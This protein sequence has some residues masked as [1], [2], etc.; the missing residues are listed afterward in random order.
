MGIK[1]LDPDEIQKK[2][3]EIIRRELAEKGYFSGPKAHADDERAG[4][5]IRCIHTNAG[6]GALW[7]MKTWQL[8]PKSVA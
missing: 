2:S 5:T 3:F 7:P 4:V 6:Y 8:R 1:Y